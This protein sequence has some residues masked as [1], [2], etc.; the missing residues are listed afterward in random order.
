MSNFHFV[1]RYTTEKELRDVGGLATEVDGGPSSVR[2][3]EAIKKAS[4][5]IN[6]ITGNIFVPVLED[7]KI[8]GTGT[9]HLFHPKCYKI[10]KLINVWFYGYYSSLFGSSKDCRVVV[11]ANE[12]E[13]DRTS[14]T[15]L[16]HK[17][18]RG[19]LNYSLE[20]IFGWIDKKNILEFTLQ[21]AITCDDTEVN[22]TSVS[23]LKIGDILTVCNQSFFICGIDTGNNTITTDPFPIDVVVTE[24]VYR[25]GCV[26]SD[27]QYAALLLA[28]DDPRLSGSFSSQE[29]ADSDFCSRLVS[30]T[31]DNYNY[32]L[33]TS[34]RSERLSSYNRGGTGNIEVDSIL[35]RYGVSR[36][37]AFV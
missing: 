37:V 25:Y 15:N 32:K 21:N 33:S 35:S 26:L 9:R 19:S 7:I 22:L 27:I 23:G 13:I 8:D 17:W 18:C 29:Q 10:I 3:L 20:G 31:T 12:Y 36:K 24:K 28:L 5:T 14:V 11:C 2:V 30:E 16:C 1:F 4:E 34:A 6:R